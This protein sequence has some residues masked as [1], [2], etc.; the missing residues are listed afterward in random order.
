MI[1][2]PQSDELK[3]SETPMSSLKD[4][5]A[6]I[7][8]GHSNV[9]GHVID[10]APKFDKF[11]LGFKGNKSDMASGPTSLSTPVKFSSAGIVQ[12]GY[13]NAIGEENNDSNVGRWMRPSVPGV[14]LSNWTF[15]DVIQVT[16][17]LE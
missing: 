7:E 10:V 12:D 2:T 14:G 16:S 3:K 13:A 5:K 15:V 4:A 17:T 9:W 8:S 6:V 1:K 11:C